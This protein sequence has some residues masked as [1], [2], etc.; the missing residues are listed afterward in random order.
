VVQE[1][2]R[3]L[4]APVILVGRYEAN[5]TVTVI[6]SLNAAADVVNLTWGVMFVGT[7]ESEPLPADLEAR[8]QEFAELVAISI[9]NA[10]SRDRRGRL[11]DQQAALRR[12]ATLAARGAGLDEIFA[13]VAEEVARVADVSGVRFVRYE[14]GGESIIVASFNDRSFPVAQAMESRA[15]E[16]RSADPRDRTCRASR[17]RLRARGTDRRWL[18]WPAGALG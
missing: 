10:E 3:V 8:L 18:R 1:I 16:Y 2:E 7:M 4:E 12:V 9:S 11:A 14:T 17:R 6:A 15:P 5:R 13:A